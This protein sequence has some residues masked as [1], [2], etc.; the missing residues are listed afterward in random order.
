MHVHVCVNDTERKKFV[1][2]LGDR[3][4]QLQVP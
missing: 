4:R 3:L 2:N 1:G